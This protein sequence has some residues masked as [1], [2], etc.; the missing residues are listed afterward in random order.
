MLTDDFPNVM[1]RDRAFME[2]RC[3]LSFSVKKLLK[4]VL[5]QRPKTGKKMNYS[6]A[7]MK[8]PVSTD[9]QTV[10]P[11]ILIKGN[12]EGENRPSFI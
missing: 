7:V 2:V 8:R 5:S 12:E 1:R 9:I 6:N 4:T 11:H 10:I 3:I